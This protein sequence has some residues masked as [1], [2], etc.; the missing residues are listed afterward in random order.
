[1]SEILKVRF[2]CERFGGLCYVC[3]FSGL[4]EACVPKFE[5]QVFGDQCLG[6]ELSKFFEGICSGF[7]GVC[8][9]GVRGVQ[10]LTICAI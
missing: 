9:Q 3:T 1:M 6:Y 7:L 10:T 8:D 2:E 5:Y 4:I